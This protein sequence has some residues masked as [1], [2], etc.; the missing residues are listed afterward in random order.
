MVLPDMKL[1]RPMALWL[2]AVI[3]MIAG[4]CMPVPASAH[5]GHAHPAFA[6]AQVAQA[7]AATRA[8]TVT[9]D[10]RVT[11]SVLQPDAALACGGPCCNA[12]GGVACCCGTGLAP[13]ESNAAASPRTNA[14]VPS[15]ALS[16]RTD[17]APDSP[18]EPPRPFA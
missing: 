9:A 13:T 2:M 11:V 8:S 18:S 14:P 4:F 17:V 16:A 1:D 7:Q 12:G 15:G 10:I 6:S 3:A 5:E